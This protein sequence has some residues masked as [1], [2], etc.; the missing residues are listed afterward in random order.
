ML[1]TSN[2]SK[3][4]EAKKMISFPLYLGMIPL[5]AK[6]DEQRKEVDGDESQAS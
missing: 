2:I 6:K 3:G 1:W 4:N 5:H